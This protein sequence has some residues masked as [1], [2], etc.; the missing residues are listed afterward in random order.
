MSGMRLRGA[1]LID[2]LGGDPVATDVTIHGDRITALGDRADADDSETLDLE[3]LTLLP[4]LIDGHT[5]LGIVDNKVEGTP[6]A[7]VA[8]QITRNFSLALDAGFTSVRDLGGIDGGYA[9]AVRVGLVRGPRAWPSGP[10]ISEAGGNGDTLPICVCSTRRW[11]QGVP[12]LSRIGESCSGPDEV[13]RAARLALRRGAT[14]VKVSLTTITTLEASDSPDTE[15]TVEEVQAAVW[16]AKAKGTYCTGHAMNHH[17]V[18]LGLA[19]GVSCFEHG[20]M[21]DE[22]TVTAAA[23]ANVWLIPTLAQQQL[24]AEGGGPDAEHAAAFVREMGESMAIAREHGLRIGLGSDLEG[25]EQHHRGL[26]L[27]LRAAL[28]DP[29]TAII[30]ATSVNADLLGRHDLGRVQAGATAD[31]IAVD[32]DPLAE[33]ELFDDPD[34][35]VLVIQGGRVVKRTGGR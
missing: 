17:G 2:G 34:R 9:E 20:G 30:G 11:N 26:E 16:E 29:M 13:R 25:P 1:T 4:G 10:I 21:A 6:L 14:Q 8:A 19:A 28:E 32:G 31:V 24:L 18:R 22:E 23:A 5:H 35:V 15:F 7:I 3:G 12:G 27:V 33:P